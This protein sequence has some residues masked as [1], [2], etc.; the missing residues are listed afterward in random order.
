M[1]T[2]SKGAL[3]RRVLLVAGLLILCTGLPAALQAQLV[4]GGT[5]QISTGSE[6]TV[7]LDNSN[8]R[9]MFVSGG[10]VP[11]VP[12][13]IG[14][15]FYFEGWQNALIGMQTPGKKE[16]KT[17]SAIVQFDLIERNVLFTQPSQRDTLALLP[18]NVAFITNRQNP[19]E[20]YV[21]VHIPDELN[22]S[23]K[24][25][26]CRLWHEGKY[27]LLESLNKKLIRGQAAGAYATAQP[28][29]YKMFS[30]FWLQ[31]P[32]G[33]FH[34]L[35]LKKKT[36]T[37]LLTEKPAELKQF[38]DDKKPDLSKPAGWAQLLSFYEQLP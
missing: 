7:V 37:E 17:L 6:K 9:G 26:I 27:K 31:K 20:A 14:N 36:V 16:V 24:P 23:G 2:N 12:G 19:D 28:D 29:Q 8:L 13:A 22:A 21:M 35:S 10:M 25:S 1:Q 15:R 4:N 30:T 33:S 3:G 38:L 32:N 18:D 11:S 34:K 5:G